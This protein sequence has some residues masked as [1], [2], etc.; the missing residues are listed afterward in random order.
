MGRQWGSSHVHARTIDHKG[1]VRKGWK[2]R[3]SH[4][5][6][7]NELEN[8]GVSGVGI[9]AIGLIIGLDCRQKE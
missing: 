3:P 4:E 2:N 5:L 1:K 7:E 8:Y 9:K 6:A